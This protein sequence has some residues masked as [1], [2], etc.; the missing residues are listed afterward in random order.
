M[1]HKESKHAHDSKKDGQMSY[2]KFLINAGSA[3]KV[4][5][6][7][8]IRFLNKELRKKRFK[9]GKI[10]VHKHRTFF[11]VDE[12]IAEHIEGAFDEVSIGGHKVKAQ[13]I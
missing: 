13:R 8:L 10:D 11:D 4:T 9:I 6:E 1:N 2:V 12:Q 7:F 3:Q 5:P